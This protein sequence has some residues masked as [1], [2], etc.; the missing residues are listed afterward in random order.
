MIQRELEV[1][2]V[3]LLVEELDELSAA[4]EAVRAAMAR[5]GRDPRLMRLALACARAMGDGAVYAAQ[6]KELLADEHDPSVR[7]ELLVEGTSA[8]LLPAELTRALED[9]LLA[10]PLSATDLTR[11]ALAVVEPR[12]GFILADR[13]VV[14]AESE[15]DAVRIEALRAAVQR[16]VEVGEPDAERAYR[17][18][19]AQ[20]GVAEDIAPAAPSPPFSAL[21]VEDVTA[22]DARL[23]AASPAREPAPEPADSDDAPAQWSSEAVGEWLDQSRLP[24]EES[25]A[26]DLRAALLPTPTDVATPREPQ[27]VDALARMMAPPAV[28]APHKSER[29][30]ERQRLETAVRARPRDRQ[31]LTALIEIELTDQ[32][33]L[34]AATYLDQLARGVDEPAQ[35]AELHYSQAS[36]LL[37]QLGEPDGWSVLLRA[38]DLYTR[39]APTLRRLVDYYWDAA[40]QESVLEM[41]DLLAVAGALDVPETGSR[42]RARICLW[43]ALDPPAHGKQAVAVALSVPAVVLVEAAVDLLQRTHESRAATPT[44]VADALRALHSHDLARVRSALSARG[45]ATSQRLATL[46]K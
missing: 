22:P 15:P 26:P 8:A 41:A 46:L 32:R 3:R 20:L 39:H 2:R 9:E 4:A 27:K 37:D 38:V 31:V 19:L 35:R 45:D 40:E 11:A 34:E 33:W 29:Q 7:S 10:L 13:A 28:A 30:A 42:T 21:P 36:L 25:S 14:A 16:A 17:A 1:E 18:R 24:N 6:L 5:F 23:P 44:A 43:G 12:V